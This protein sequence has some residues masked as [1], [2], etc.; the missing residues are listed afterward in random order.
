MLLWIF[1]W[2]LVRS[3]KARTN[4]Y[5]GDFPAPVNKNAYITQRRCFNLQP[6][7]YKNLA[8]KAKCFDEALIKFV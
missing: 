7:K 1:F 3:I 2:L 6:S 4:I 8:S 5:L